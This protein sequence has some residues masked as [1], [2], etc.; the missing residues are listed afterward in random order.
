MNPRKIQKSQFRKTLQNQR[1]IKPSSLFWKVYGTTVKCFDARVLGAINSALGDADSIFVLKEPKKNRGVDFNVSCV[2]DGDTFRLQGHAPF[3]IIF[4]YGCAGIGLDMLGSVHLGPTVQ[5][6]LAGSVGMLGWDLRR[7]QEERLQPVRNALYGLPTKYGIQKPATPTGP[8]VEVQAHFHGPFSAFDE[9]GCRCL[10]TDQ[11][12][13]RSG[14]YLWTISVKGQ[15][16]LWYVGQTRRSFGQRMGEHLAGFLSGQYQIHDPDG[17]SRGE[18]RLAD[19]S[20]NGVWP[21][22]LPYLLQNY[23]SLLPKITGLIRL[24]KFHL[25]PLVGDAHL[26]DRVEG[27]IGRYYK[28]HPDPALRDFITPG[29]KLPAAVPYD[30]PMRLI[31]SSETPLAGLPAEICE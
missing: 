3:D 8:P 23:E 21:R 2:G 20:I 26:H 4:G 15:E 5:E 28:A 17:L 24:I 22:T 1:E 6:I 30:N 7:L 14:V 11:L 27:A 12:A 16:C 10:F 13:A 19:G 9:A 25:C 18:Q 29:L 31:L